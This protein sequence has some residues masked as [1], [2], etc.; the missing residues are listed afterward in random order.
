MADA[1]FAPLPEPPYWA[2]IFAARLGA[3]REGYAQMAAAMTRLASGQPGF[4]GV[5]SARGPDGF[6]ITVSYWKD[7]DSIRA[8]KLRAEHLGAQKLGKSRWYADYVLRIGRIERAY[9]GPAGR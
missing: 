4:L 6:G 5:E 8:W 3:E 7:E 1:A 9:D 2:V